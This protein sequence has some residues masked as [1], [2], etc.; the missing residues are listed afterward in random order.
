MK[1]LL[2]TEALPHRRLV[3]FLRALWG[4]ELRVL[5]LSTLPEQSSNRP[6]YQHGTLYLPSASPPGVPGTFS[7]YLLAAAAH[8]AAHLCF[9]PDRLEVKRLTPLHVAVISLLEDARVERLASA[10]YPGLLRLWSPF[11][12]ARADGASTAGALLARLARALHDRAHRDADA[13]VHNGRERF[14]SAMLEPD[15]QASIRR[16]GNLLANDLGQ[17]RVQF[18]AKDYVVEPAYRDDNSGLWRFE[19]NSTDAAEDGADSEGARRVERE[20]HPRR[21][22]EPQECPGALRDSP[23]PA[24]AAEASAE[25]G[26]AKA[27]YPEWDYVITRARPAFCTVYEAEGPLGDPASLTADKEHAPARRRLARFAAR[28][29]AG[30]PNQQRRLLDGDRLDWPRALAAMVARASA[31]QP[32]PRVYCRVRS[33]AEPPTVLLLLDLSESLNATAQGSSNSLLQVARTASELFLSSVARVVHEVAVFG[34][35]SNGRHQVSCFYFKHFDEP[36]DA[37]VEARLAGMRAHSSTRL[38]AALRHAGRALG[39]RGSHG[40][41]VLVLVSDGEPSDVDVHDPEYLLADARHA[42]VETRRQGVVSYCI[43]LDPKAK[44]SVHRIFGAGHYVLLDRPD[45][46]PERLSELYQRL[47]Q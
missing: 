25:A 8:G 44:P 7:N 38:G 5:P 4:L 16:L 23:I 1:P 11:H 33:R 20:S 18:N 36:C 41:K 9:G 30:R 3:L 22:P 24:R 42:I 32:D 47:A 14:E 28:L 37:R 40:R 17:M 35:S 27:R 21:S 10:E 31:V 39:A 2:P 34:F 13:W 26:V 12:V 46:L 15:S 45:R 19:Q 6:R 29:R 43:G